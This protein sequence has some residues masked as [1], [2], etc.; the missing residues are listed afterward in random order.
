MSLQGATLEKNPQFHL[1]G[2]LYT[3]TSLQ[4][5]SADLKV[6]EQQLDARIKQAPK[7]FHNAPIVIDLQKIHRPQID[8]DVIQLKALLQSKGLIPVG[9]KGG[10]SVQHAAALAAGFAILPEGSRGKDGEFSDD[11]RTSSMMNDKNA[12]ALNS[13][14]GS[15]GSNTV[16]ITE[17]VRSG[18]QIYAENGDL[19]ILSSVSHGAELLADGHIHI[20]GALRGRAL[21]GVTGDQSARIFC[22]SLEAELI[23]IAGHYKISEDFEKTLWKTSVDIYW[24]EG[25]LQ[26]RPL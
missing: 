9:V 5:L 18:Q 22:Q 21:A 10:S 23:S 24:E 6:L 17:P 2:G 3:L 4:M 13:E 12:E 7:F 26:I 14:Q 15:K 8:F 11:A 1:K 19:I 20:Y 25:R 16:L